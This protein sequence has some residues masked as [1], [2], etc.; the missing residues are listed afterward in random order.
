[1]SWQ[2]AFN[3]KGDIRALNINNEEEK[4]TI[5]WGKHNEEENTIRW[6]GMIELNI[7]KQTSI[8]KHILIQNNV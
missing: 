8:N 7:L 5:E 4:N 2:T 3:K 1:M 6:R